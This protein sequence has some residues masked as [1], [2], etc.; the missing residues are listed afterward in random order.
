MIAIR[1]KER[2]EGLIK[3]L[4]KDYPSLHDSAII[5]E[6]K[7]LKNSSM[8]AKKIGER[9]FKIQVDYRKYKNANDNQILGAFAH[10]LVHFEFYT[11]WS[12]FRYMIDF[13]FYRISKKYVR[14]MESIVDSIIIKKGY[15]KALMAN[16]EMRRRDMT[17]EE[18]ARAREIYMFG[19]DISKKMRDLKYDTKK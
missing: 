9:N 17:K 14:K 3:S 8:F 5:I 2:C 19:D 12:Y 18:F 16:R 4:R 7:N 10:E 11:K 13:L 6:I 1:F 15:G